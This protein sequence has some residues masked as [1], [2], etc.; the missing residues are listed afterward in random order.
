MGAFSG[1]RLMWWNWTFWNSEFLTVT[2]LLNQHVD[3]YLLVTQYMP[4]ISALLSTHCGSGMQFCPQYKH[5]THTL[6]LYRHAQLNS[7]PMVS[8]SQSLPV[9]LCMYTSAIVWVKFMSSV[10][11]PVYT[12]H[13]SVHHISSPA[14]VTLLVSAF[15][16]IHCSPLWILK[17]FILTEAQ[18][19]YSG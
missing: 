17:A 11:M 15:T 2:G 4:L 10:N 19:V 5:Y 12:C 3:I 9:V 18:T 13:F 7:F 6:N 8:A 16:I 1:C 14:A